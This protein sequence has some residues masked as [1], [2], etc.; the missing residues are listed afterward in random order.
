MLDKESESKEK[1][2]KIDSKC[3]FSKE[4]VNTGHQPELDFFK[5]YCIF[6]IVI[7]HMYVNFT[8]GILIAPLLLTLNII[9]ANTL[10][11]LMGLGMKYSRHNEPKHCISRG[12]ALLTISQF[13]NLIRDTLPN[14]IAW[15]TT[16]HQKFISRALLV[17]ET[18]IL[19]FAGFAYLFL[20]L[21][22][23]LKLS[24]NFILIIGIIMNFANVFIYKIMKTPDNFFLR[25][26]L[27]Y[28]IFIEN[29]EAFFPLLAYFIF[30]SFGNWLGGILQKVSNKDKFYNLILIFGLPISPIF[31]YFISNN[32]IPFFPQYNRIEIYCM[33]PGPFAIIYCINNL[34]VVAIFYKIQKLFK[35]R[36]PK[37]VSHA[38]KNLNQY[39]IISYAITMQMNVFLKAT[40]GEN[41]PST[42]KYPT[43][44]AIILFLLSGILIDINDKYIHF[45]IT[46]LKNPMRNY[47][48]TFI[49]ILTA[50]S[51]IYIY[52]KVEVYANIW[53]N[54]LNEA[55]T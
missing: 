47:V 10:M 24:D 11:F 29:A 50:I 37:L 4:N 14:L 36:I 30:V 17:L 15:W 20:A 12:I 48:F 46:T 52:P 26:F 8:F 19:T 16:G 23:K 6:L 3:I 2:E 5:A 25:Q 41:Y 54:Y 45:T 35:G 43:L 33:M 38:S 53:N 32:N 22:K 18:D 13:F 31:I 9:S 7:V 28:F 27:G 51:V 39:Y 42:L 55:E 21:L 44:Y 49:W 1:K 34:I 40:K